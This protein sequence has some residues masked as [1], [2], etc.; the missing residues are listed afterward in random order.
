VE[1]Y[2]TQ[3]WHDSCI[4]ANPEAFLHPSLEAARG[5]VSGQKGSASDDRV[6]VSPLR[7][8]RPKS[9]NKPR[10]R[11]DSISISLCTFSYLH[12]TVARDRMTWN[13]GATQDS[14]EGILLLQDVS[15]S[16]SGGIRV[17]RGFTVQTEGGIQRKRSGKSKRSQITSRPIPR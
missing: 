16:S 10:L 4:A 5:L 6:V 11:T 7:N 3:C 1:L 14:E 8:Y 15:V 17:T 2:K 13:A 12:S 9:W